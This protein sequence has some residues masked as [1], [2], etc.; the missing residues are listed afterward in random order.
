MEIVN[1]LGRRKAAIARV[2]INDGKGSILV[3]NRDVKEYF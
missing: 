3:N 2:Y 1:A